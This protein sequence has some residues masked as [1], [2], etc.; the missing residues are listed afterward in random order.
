MMLLPT[1]LLATLAFLDTPAPE[2]PLALVG[3]RVQPRAG[4][5]VL[6]GVTILIRE[7][8]IQAVGV[9]L[10]VPWDARAV[11]VTGLTLT[12]ALVDA[13]QLRELDFAPSE[14][15]Q[16]RPE[17]DLRDPLPAMP[18]AHRAGLTPD[19]SAWSRL[20]QDA[21]D[22]PDQRKA[23]FGLALVAP[24]GE[25]LSGSASWLALS[26]R[27]P[28]E[29]VLQADVAQ[30]GSLLWRTGPENYE[31]NRYPAT[32][33]G[34]MAH[35]RQ[36]L[37]DARREVELARR[38]AGENPPRRAPQ[39]AV[40]Q[41]LL[42]I[43]TG[44]RPLMLEAREEEDLRLALGLLE[45]F[46]GMRLIVCGATEAYELTD[47][48]ARHDVTV[49]HDL[50]FGREPK[51]P[52]ATEEQESSSAETT[53]LSE[54][55]WDVAE[56]LRLR[57]HERAE[58]LERVAG[59]AQLR[60]AGL[61]V[62]FAS[63][64]RSPEKLLE[65]LQL[66]MQH[67]GLDRE[68]A[69]RALTLSPF[70][71][72]PEGS[73]GGELRA[74]APALLAAWSGEPLAEKSKV[75]LMVIEGRLFDLR[76]AEAEAEESPEKDKDKAQ[77]P[78]A[79]EAGSAAAAGAAEAAPARPAPGAWPVEL[80]EDRLPSFQ[81]GGDVLLRGA[82]LLTASQGELPE[83]DLLVRGGRIAAI[84]RGLSAP[85]GVKV[86]EA[87]GRFV[88][89]GVIDCHAHVAIRGGINEWT[90]VV[91]PE[92][93]IEDE[94]DPDDVGIYRAL[95]G[96]VTAARLLHGSSNAIGGRHA[97]IK[98]RWG[99]TAPELLFAG[100]PAGVKFALGENPKRS[101]H[102][103]GTRFPN[104]RM[105][106]EAVL[107]RSFEAAAH[108]AEEWRLYESERGA[109]R[110]P[111]PPRRD[112]RLEA[113]A[114]I[115]D[116]SI[117]VHSHCYRA[118]EILMLLRVAE[119]YGFQVRTLQHVLEGYKVAA[120]I[121]AHGAGGSTFVDWWGYK[122]EA[123][124]ATPYAAAL[125]HEGGVL[126][127]VNSDS[128]EHLRRLY[129]EAAKTVKYGGVPEEE[130]LRMVTLNPAQQ[131][132]L[133]ERVGS[134]EVGKDADLAVYSH[135]PFDVRTRCLM[136]FVDGEL[137]FERRDEVWQE[138]SALVAQRVSAGRGE[139]SDTSGAATDPPA[140]SATSAR[141][142]AR[143]IPQ[144]LPR[145]LPAGA[146]E[147]LALPGGATRAPSNPLRP[148]GPPVA[149]VGGTVHTMEFSEGRPVVHAPGVVLMENGLLRGVYAGHAAPPPEFRVVDV[150]GLQVWPGLID[151][152][153]SVGLQEIDSVRGTMDVSEIGGNQPDLRASAAWHPDAAAV[154]VTRANGITTVLAVP[155]GEGLLGQ[156]S[157]MALEGWTAGEAL[158]Q[159]SVALHI[160]A[161]RTL[162]KL[163]EEDEEEEEGEEEG[164]A[165]ES[166]EA[167]G[168]LTV[169]V[170]R[171][172][173]DLRASL[174]EAREYVRL[175]AEAAARSA[176]GP[177]PDTRLA[178]LAPYALGEGLV[179]F[180]ADHADQIMDVLRFAREERLRVA[181]AGG[182]QAWRVAEHLALADV[183]V[184]VGPVLTL[185][186]E[187]HDPHDAPYRNAAVL[188]A[189]GV[190]IAFRSNESASARDLPYHAGMA[191]A[192]GLPEDEAL[193]ALTSGSAEI[194]GLGERVGSLSAGRRADVLVTDGSP[195]QIRTQVRQLYID[196]RAVDLS[197]R[198]TQL[199]ERYRQRLLD[200]A[201][202]SR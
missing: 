14:V 118:D 142:A 99:A 97:V 46:P 27:P 52:L 34:V 96:G 79:A 119:D 192:F 60:R 150:T 72:L 30:V 146:I 73:A 35:L 90:R 200:P 92:V 126:M 17:N 81:T 87:A 132:G 25:L 112:L 143:G 33:M 76:S 172:W 195:L 84:G 19:R 189:A 186:L 88:M 23:G 149:L 153:G 173:A 127:S 202:P 5:P 161:P 68:E 64:A 198:H 37:L 98:M 70:E 147:T 113:L 115:L 7:G 58:W 109:G 178:A 148:A 32:L 133:D 66:A 62:C 61:R 191:V 69:L 2:Q 156:S 144:D 22:E 168:S 48:L 117:D 82:T 49:V 122:I 78:S 74:G 139:A 43:V 80:D 29:A 152:G 121:A 163:P 174:R 85:E 166:E 160:R 162:R 6:E 145:P 171:A 141:P 63:L 140:D 190:R 13:L 201:T 135:H 18:A 154:A 165:A 11:D 129:L 41:A 57:L 110:D 12:P 136:T 4:E 151:A 45:E 36:A 184:L 55:P 15:Q 9:G 10:A 1:L 180:H 71:M 59:V 75:R 128:D 44:E 91:T 38:H 169:R 111:D 47:E 3:G 176:P 157:A 131:L 39:D 56:P 123:H 158:V 42:P 28:R 114:G 89:P 124:D 185:P 134:L 183:A 8:R 103:P 101:N 106:V 193:R 31:G 107:R 194:L 130:A 50:D 116:A 83:T 24:R 108:Y 199:Y 86:V 93:T 40:L 67:G 54:Q 167:G 51:D 53:P 105:G 77:D 125:M 104:T 137:L 155:Q 94:V 21:T 20:P 102:N 120:E 138:W 159:D 182:Q 187:R 181:I 170:E 188:H 26:G 196:G 100:A 16:G 197:T 179:I 65:G 177:A 175:S 95:A 164:D